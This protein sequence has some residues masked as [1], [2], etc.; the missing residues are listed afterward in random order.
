G[1][2]RGWGRLIEHEHGWR[3]QYAAPVALLLPAAGLRPARLRP[4]SR[5]RAQ[6]LEALAASYAIPLITERQA[7]EWLNVTPTD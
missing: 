5:R 1:I 2:V 6:E 3:A 7:A 4:R